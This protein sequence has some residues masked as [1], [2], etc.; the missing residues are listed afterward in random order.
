MC[1]GGDR[2]GLGPV[3]TCASDFPRSGERKPWPASVKG[4]GGSGHRGANR[5]GLRT[6][7]PVIEAEE[8]VIDARGLV[9]P[10]PV[11]ALAQ[12]ANRAEPGSRLVLL[13]DDPVA[14]RCSSVVPMREAQLLE[15]DRRPDH[16]R[17][18]VSTTRPEGR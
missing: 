9:C 13:A 4:G 1:A 11:I 7:E 10:H 6:Y 5:W 3:A 2:R 12:A 15:V 16:W 17:F 18:V 8:V 14:N